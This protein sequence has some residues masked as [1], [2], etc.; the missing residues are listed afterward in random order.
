M[1]NSAIEAVKPVKVSALSTGYVAVSSVR[2]EIFVG[3]V[4]EAQ[5]TDVPLVVRYFPEFPVWVGIGSVGVELTH[6]DPL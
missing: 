4:I 3:T 6:F 2:S 5:L 1:F